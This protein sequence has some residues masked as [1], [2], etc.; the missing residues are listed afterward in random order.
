MAI[1]GSG[2]LLLKTVDLSGGG[3][4]GGGGGVGSFQVSGICKVY[5][6]AQKG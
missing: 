4:G 6:K 3:G 2:Q 1:F 5:V